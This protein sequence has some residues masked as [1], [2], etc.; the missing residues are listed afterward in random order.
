EA[1]LAQARDSRKLLS[2]Q[3]VLE[4]TQSRLAMGQARQKTGVAGQAVA[5]A[6][7]NLRITLERFKQGVALNTDVLDAE[8]ALLQAKI[9][10][11]QAAIDLALAQASLQKALGH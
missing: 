7:E 3:A 11:T 10:R 8:A 9:T 5:Q 2:D 6:E 1:Q 4:V